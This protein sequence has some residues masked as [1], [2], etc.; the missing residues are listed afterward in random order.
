MRKITKQARAKGKDI[1]VDDLT[2]TVR[3]NKPFLELCKE[4]GIALNFFEGLAE[5]IIA[6]YP[7]STSLAYDVLMRPKVE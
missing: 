6:E 7:P 4:L 2:Q 1:C 5:R 3:D